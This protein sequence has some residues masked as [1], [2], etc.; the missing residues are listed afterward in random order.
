MGSSLS[1]WRL[2]LTLLLPL[3]STHTFSQYNLSLIKAPNVLFRAGG[4]I[5]SHLSGKSD[6]LMA[7]K[8]IEMPERVPKLP[9]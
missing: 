9:S 3:P 8:K 4:W 5:S 6:G 1:G 2:M 7:K